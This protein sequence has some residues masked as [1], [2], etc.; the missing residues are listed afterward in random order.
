MAFNRPDRR[1][2]QRS[3]PPCRRTRQ[4]PAPRPRRVVEN[5]EV[6]NVLDRVATM[7]D[8]QVREQY[9]LLVDKGRANLSPLE[10]F[11]LERIE[12]RLDAEDRDPVLEARERQWQEERT[13]LLDSIE[14]L[15]AKLRGL[16]R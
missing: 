8:Q 16:P 10:R 6:R 4:S 12:A 13:E 15:L 9:H 11:E 3:Q 14:Q 2:S 7:S 5:Q 1:I